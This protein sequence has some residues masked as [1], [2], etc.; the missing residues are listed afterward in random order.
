MSSVS[1]CSGVKGAEGIYKVE[2]VS[3]VEESIWFRRSEREGVFVQIW[4][5]YAIKIYSYYNGKG[6][7]Y[8]WA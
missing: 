3:K 4:I 7:V 6:A 8:V 2:V 5:F 1:G